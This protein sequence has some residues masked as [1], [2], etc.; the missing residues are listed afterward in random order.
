MLLLLQLN[1]L[2]LLQKIK[3]TLEA[4]V[5]ES[6]LLAVINQHSAEVKTLKQ[7][8]DKEVSWKSSSDFPEASY[9]VFGE[10]ASHYFDSIA[11][12]WILLILIRSH[13]VEH[14]SSKYMYMYYDLIME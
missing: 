14:L 9:P 6:R 2:F 7:F 13:R 5:T 4:A 10:S 11:K 8:H 12:D 1:F 3:V